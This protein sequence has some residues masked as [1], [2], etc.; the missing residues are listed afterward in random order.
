MR[1]LFITSFHAHISRNILATPVLSIL[2]SRQ[3]LRLVILVPD[4]KVSYFEEN[5]GPPASGGNVFI[6]G[7][8]TYQPSKTWT[9]LF[10]KRFSRTFFNT[11]TTRA[12]RRWKYYWDRK[13]WYFLLSGSAGFFGRSFSVQKLV[14]SLDLKFSPKGLFYP[15]FE[16]YK[17]AAVF[18][19]DIHNENDVALMQDARRLG[20]P[21]L[22]MWR[23]WDNP[24][25][26]MLR[27]FPDKLLCGSPELKKETLKLHYYPEEKIVLTGHPNYDR[28]LKGPI[29]SR[30][31]FF[32]H[33]KLDPR[34]KLI[35]FA[36]GGDK[37]IKHNDLD[38]NVLKILS[39]ADANILV[40]YPPGEDVKLLE[41]EKWPSKISF[42]KPGFRFG[43]RPGEFVI[44]KE[45]DDNFIDELYYSNVV[46]TGPTS[47]CLDAALLDKPVIVADVY[48]TPRN[49]YQKGW[50]FVQE[51]IHKLLET[52]GVW[53]A[54]TREEFLKAVESY[55]QNPAL[56]KEGRAE[57][58]K[59]W[60][61]LSDGR[62]SERVARELIDFLKI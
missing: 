7:F 16:K 59:K 2:K 53:Y 51:L 18:S 30:A 57:I 4:Y 61:S 27:V 23:S 36:P 17:P 33:F 10:F 32:S 45:D 29:R 8:K 35:L 5:F 20:I 21:I 40:R 60:F 49:F 25:Q 19:T 56:H 38:L 54:D 58:R 34:K 50:G 48:P 46:V 37:I 39:E 11:G 24:T 41:G 9:G 6:E 52:K 47:V 62:A 44:R 13:L 42:D 22:G 12:K 1:T 15:L 14:R 28:Y 3:D 43:S 31:E 55:F 26:Q